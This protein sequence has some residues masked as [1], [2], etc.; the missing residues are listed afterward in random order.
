MTTEFAFAPA[1]ESRIVKIQRSLLKCRGSLRIANGSI[2]FC[3]GQRQGDHEANKLRSPEIRCAVSPSSGQISQ[4][5]SRGTSMKRTFPEL[6]TAQRLPASFAAL[7]HC[8]CTVL[9]V[10]VGN[11][12]PAADLRRRAD[13]QSNAIPFDGGSG[14]AMREKSAQPTREMAALTL[15]PRAHAREPLICQNLFRRFN[16]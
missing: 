9:A 8:L 6:R 5:H 13:F 14:I 2:E 16:G 3:S 12:T 1:T 11:V 15:R 10:P 7:S 4:G